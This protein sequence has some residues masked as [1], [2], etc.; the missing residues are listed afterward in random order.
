MSDVIDIN[1]NKKKKQKDENKNPLKITRGGIESSLIDYL[2]REDDKH[3]P[4]HMSNKDKHPKFDGWSYRKGIGAN[5]L[6][7]L[8]KES[9]VATEGS[10]E[11]LVSELVIVLSAFNDPEQESYMYCLNHKGIIDLARRFIS[12]GREIK[13]WPEPCGFK[14]S[15]GYFFKRLD[16]DP[17]WG[18]SRNDFPF[19]SH[20]LMRMTNSQAFCERVGSMFVKNPDRKQAIW[21]HG[22]GDSGKTLWFDILRYLV[23]ERGTA[24]IDNSIV[25]DK[26]GLFPL[27]DKI[28]WIGDEIDPRFIRS[29]KFK[30][31]TGGSAVQINPKGSA[32]FDVYLKGITFLNSN[33]PPEI[34]NDSGLINRL[35][36]CGI[37][38]VPE[39]ERLSPEN[40]LS[41][42]KE[43][44]P[45]FVGY[46]IE[47]YTKLGRG[48]TIVPE[49]TEDIDDAIVSFESSL[50]KAYEDIFIEDNKIQ[51][52]LA[53]VTPS[54]LQGLFSQW[55][56]EFP[57]LGRSI[58]ISKFQKYVG[59]RSG[60]AFLIKIGG[61]VSR[62]FPGIKDSKRYIHWGGS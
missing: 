8:D 49:S 18:C 35:I 13:D 19:L 24:S 16:F 12:G 29:N 10:L 47:S 28:L 1:K 57:K 37:T 42:A 45:Q 22:D 56:Q 17:E 4:M 11:E 5:R 31:I 43:E 33:H 27:R 32:Q 23:G 21:L 50:C 38:K 58:S 61:K 36:V 2:D 55:C 51:R 25:D 44:L 30:R 52:R 60:A 34:P 48:A 7:I 62:Y 3:L 41:A 54:V 9:G 15:P 39:R 46:C 53:K 20:A 40:A 6:V 26:F 59:K 14:S